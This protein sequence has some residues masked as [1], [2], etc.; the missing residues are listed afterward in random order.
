MRR[1]K[2]GEFEISKKA[3]NNKQQAVV[4][5]NETRSFR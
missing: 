1:W 4:K 2:R 5:G 3:R